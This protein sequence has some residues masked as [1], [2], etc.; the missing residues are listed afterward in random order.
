MISGFSF[1]YDNSLY[2]TPPDVAISVHW[3][4][5]SWHINGGFNDIVNQSI[6]MAMI[7]NPVFRWQYILDFDVRYDIS[8]SLAVGLGYDDG[9]LGLLLYST[10]FK[11]ELS[12]KID[13]FA[14][15]IN[16]GYEF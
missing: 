11:M 4:H 6:W 15:G 7:D 9:S 2:F 12:T 1:K 5:D 13:R 10:G 16:I 14:F 8:D 3:N